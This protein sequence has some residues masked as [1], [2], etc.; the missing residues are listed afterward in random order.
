MNK[1]V[2][3]EKIRVEYKVRHISDYMFFYYT[4]IIP[5][6]IYWPSETYD[7]YKVWNSYCR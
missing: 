3:D 2:L 1:Y 4:C 5:E 7:V 6:F